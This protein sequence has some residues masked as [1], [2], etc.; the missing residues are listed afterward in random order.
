LAHIGEY[1]SQSFADQRMGDSAANAIA[2]AG[3][4]GRLAGSNKGFRRLMSVGLLRS[5]RGLP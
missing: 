1:G 5:S 3:H 2:S 4:E